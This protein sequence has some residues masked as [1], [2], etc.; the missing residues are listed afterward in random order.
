L[1]VGDHVRAQT[2]RMP[3]E[4]LPRAAILEFTSP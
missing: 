1:R 2:F 3:G 4:T